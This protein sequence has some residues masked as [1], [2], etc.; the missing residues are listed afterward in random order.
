M[1]GKWKALFLVISF[2]F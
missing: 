2:L 1:Q